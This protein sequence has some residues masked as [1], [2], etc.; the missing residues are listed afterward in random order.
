MGFGTLFLCAAGLIAA[1]AL[2]I[3]DARRH[4]HELLRMERMRGS[5]LYYEIYPLV[6]HARRYVLDRVQVE[7]DR[8]IFY[9]MYPPRKI[10]EFSITGSGFRPL[11]RERVRTLTLLLAEDMPALQENGHYRL[12]KYRMIRPNGIR[13]D[14]YLYVMRSNYKTTL[15]LERQRARLY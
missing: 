4:Q 15:M 6:L 2:L 7:R 13:D 8:V 10:G 9:S 1:F 3:Y 12:K 14:G 11:T 5:A